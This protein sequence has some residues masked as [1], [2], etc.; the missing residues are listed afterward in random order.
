VF[1]TTSRTDGKDVDS[2]D[3]AVAPQ[4]EPEKKTTQ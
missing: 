1:H 2:D 3:E 4:P